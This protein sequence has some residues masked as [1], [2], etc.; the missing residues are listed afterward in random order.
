MA[1]TIVNK[2]KLTVT[3]LSGDL[4]TIDAT[5]QTALRSAT[6]ANADVIIDIQ[7]V[8]NRTSNLVSAYIIW[9]DQ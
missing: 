6:F 3:E 7:I 5:I 9:E 8:R 2:A 1:H 4:G